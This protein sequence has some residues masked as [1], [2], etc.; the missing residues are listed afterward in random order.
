MLLE[1]WMFILV[2]L[3]EQYQLLALHEIV[4]VRRQI[5]KPLDCFSVGVEQICE[6][7]HCVSFL[8][9]VDAVKI[10]LLR[11]YLLFF[12]SFH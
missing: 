4:L 7:H 5:V 2:R 6:L 8:D 1:M 3:V 10:K 9:S 12:L 11:F